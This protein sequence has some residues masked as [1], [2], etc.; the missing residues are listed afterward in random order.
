M[1]PLRPDWMELIQQFELV[2]MQY[3]L[4]ATL[5]P[6]GIHRQLLS[7]LFIVNWIQHDKKLLGGERTDC[8]RPILQLTWNEVRLRSCAIVLLQ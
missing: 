4:Q 1:H 3:H 7:T 5:N 6:Q 8:M 2:E